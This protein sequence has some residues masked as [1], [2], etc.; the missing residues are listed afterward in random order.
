MHNYDYSEFLSAKRKESRKF[1][2]D[3]R[4]D[5][6]GHEPDQ[7]SLS[8]VPRLDRR[9]RPEELVGFLARSVFN[10]N[11]DL[12]D[13]KRGELSRALTAAVRRLGGLETLS[14]STKRAARSN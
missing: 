2:P 10:H 3:R 11:R 1:K 6:D 4:P 12:G 7:G 9:L 13:Y 14:G 8:Q 5:R